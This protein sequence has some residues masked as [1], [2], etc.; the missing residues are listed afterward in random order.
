[1]I[2]PSI[3]V[4]LTKRQTE[5]LAPILGLVK[6]AFEN[7]EPGTTIGQISDDGKVLRV[8]F[9]DAEAGMAIIQAVLEHMD[10]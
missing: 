9:A 8:A 4:K 7:G 1:M 10:T 6:F 2:T 5:T 3:Y